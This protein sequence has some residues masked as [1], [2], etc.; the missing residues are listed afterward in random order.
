MTDE[1][2]RN[3]DRAVARALRDRIIAADSDAEI[4]ADLAKLRCITARTPDLS[5]AKTLSYLINFYAKDH[6]KADKLKAELEALKETAQPAV[7]NTVASMA[8]VALPENVKDLEGV[9]PDSEARWPV[10]VL[11]SADWQPLDGPD[12][13]Q[14]TALAAATFP[15][16][17]P[18]ELAVQAVAAR[19]A[20]L[21]C[22]PGF[23][24]TEVLVK[25]ADG[26]SLTH[27]AL[28][29]PD[30]ALQINGTST[31]IHM[32][33]SGM[34]KGAEKGELNRS[35]LDLS[36][37]EKAM[38]YLRFFCGCVHADEGGFFIIED[39][40]QLA[41]R[42][43]GGAIPEK[44]FD[45]IFP[46]KFIPP[47]EIEGEVIDEDTRRA[48]GKPNGAASTTAD[49][50]KPKAPK[51]TQRFE[52]VLLYSN[53]I[54]HSRFSILP[55]GIVEMLDDTPVA[56]ELDINRDGFIDDLRIVSGTAK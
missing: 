48:N 53:A 28:Y 37:I 27:V 3:V 1:H 14:A 47:T 51:E 30:R 34:R 8:V 49:I 54:F 42:W 20:E 12:V 6:P 33:N 13:T 24:A 23:R 32:L 43:T 5:L 18:S 29:G 41:E 19:S 52:A 38:A 25:K 26:H 44:L 56:T 50:N 2:A 4:E 55:S 11:F 39:K 17:F 46:I 7:K 10:P 21:L 15:D 16:H 40:A 45:V 31:G 36:D 35:P 9:T 22:Y